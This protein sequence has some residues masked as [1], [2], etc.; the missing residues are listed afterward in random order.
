MRPQQ[1]DPALE[2][3]L[4]HL[5]GLIDALTEL[6]QLHGDDDVC[7]DRTCSLCNNLDGLL[8][9]A[10]GVEAVLESDV[11][12]FPAMRRRQLEDRRRRREEKTE[13]EEADQ[14]VTVEGRR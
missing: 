4:I 10:R 5:W 6:A 8:W 14:P 12:T 7:Q 1:N 2:R 3:A 11:L 13:A 9:T